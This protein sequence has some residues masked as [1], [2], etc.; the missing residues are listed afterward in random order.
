VIAKTFRPLSHLQTGLLTTG[1]RPLLL[2]SARSGSWQLLN[3]PPRTPPFFRQFCLPSFLG[4]RFRLGSSPHLCDGSLLFRRSWLANR[5]QSLRWR[6]TRRGQVA[7]SRNCFANSSSWTLVLGRSETWYV[8]GAF[9]FVSS[10]AADSCRRSF[11]MGFA[12]GGGAGAPLS[13]T[14][15]TSSIK[16][17]MVR[18]KWGTEM[19]T[20]LSLKIWAIR[21][22]LSPLRCASRILPCTVS[23]HRSW[24]VSGSVGL[25][26][27]GPLEED[28]RQRI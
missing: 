2:S 21:W 25:Q 26:S 8:T 14:R 13:P 10:A 27:C 20:P 17:R 1:R 22:T 15:S 12:G 24:A 23:T 19:S 18:T 9:C 28:T 4:Q 6:Q 3:R 16:R 7:A 11:A 5:L